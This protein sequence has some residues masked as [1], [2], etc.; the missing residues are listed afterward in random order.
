MEGRK[1]LLGYAN[2]VFN[3]NFVAKGIAILESE[4]GRWVSMPSRKNKKG[5]FINICHPIN[6]K[7]RDMITREIFEKLE[8]LEKQEK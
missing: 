4:K 1:P 5:K 8:E 2:V 7:T 3:N 6:H